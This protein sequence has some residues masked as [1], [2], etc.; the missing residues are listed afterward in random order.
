MDRAE[1]GGRGGLP[2]D[3]AVDR[4]VGHARR[5]DRQRLLEF[6]TRFEQQFVNQAASRTLEESMQSGWDVLRGLPHNE[7]AR[8]SDAQIRKHLEEPAHA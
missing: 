3:R 7:L 2:L 5:Q 6:G 1:D 8:L 4:E